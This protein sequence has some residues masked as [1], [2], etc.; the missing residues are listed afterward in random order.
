MARVFKKL[1]NT[2]PGEVLV[3]RVLH[4]DIVT[5]MALTVVD[6][7]PTI[8]DDRIHEVVVEI[9]VF[10]YERARDAA[11]S[12]YYDDG[13]LLLL[14]YWLISPA[15]VPAALAWCLFGAKPAHALMRFLTGPEPKKEDKT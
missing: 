10:T 7:L 3:E 9:R 2:Q 12:E 14:G 5:G 11:R 1:K 4:P 8:M 6:Q 15:L 13:R